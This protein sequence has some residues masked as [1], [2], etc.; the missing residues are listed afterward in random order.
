MEELSKGIGAN[1]AGSISCLIAMVIYV[2]LAVLCMLSVINIDTF[3]VLS[4]VTAI[5]ELLLLI[6]VSIKYK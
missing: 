6:C 4:V 1:E 5:K 3:I 2:A